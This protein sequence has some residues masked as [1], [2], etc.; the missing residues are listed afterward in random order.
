MVEYTREQRRIDQR[1]AHLTDW[2][3]MYDSNGL[4]LEAQKI[5]HEEPKRAAAMRAKAQRMAD[6]LRR[7]AALA[8]S[9]R[10]L[11]ERGTP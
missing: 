4:S 10:A 1:Y 8:E 9:L 2:E 11:A 6:C 7:R 3:L 5:E